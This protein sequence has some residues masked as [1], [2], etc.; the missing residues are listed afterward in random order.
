MG[1]PYDPAREVPARRPAGPGQIRDQRGARG[2]RGL[3][4]GGGLGGFVVVV[5][6]ALLA[7]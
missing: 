4:V 5:V 2:G 1:D 6:L 7:A 3:A